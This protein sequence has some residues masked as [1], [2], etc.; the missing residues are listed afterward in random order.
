MRALLFMVTAGGI[1]LAAL[2]L[3][4][5]FAAQQF[6]YRRLPADLRPSNTYDILLWAS[7][8][9]IAAVGL[10]AVLA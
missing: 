7:I 1:A 6:R 10:M 9:A 5:A 2:L 4:V 3:V 8:A